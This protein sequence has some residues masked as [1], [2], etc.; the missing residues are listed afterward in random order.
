LAAGNDIR[1][2]ECSAEWRPEET[3]AWRA[4]LTDE[5][6]PELVLYCPDC[7]KREFDE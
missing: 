3:T 5:S 6:P 7:A 4:Y 1:C 2:L